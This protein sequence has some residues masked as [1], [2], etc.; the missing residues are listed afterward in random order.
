MDADP[1]LLAILAGSTGLLLGAYLVGKWAQLPRIRR[2][3]GH[4]RRCVVDLAT[5]MAL[6]DVARGDRR[7]A[8]DVFLDALSRVLED[9]DTDSILRPTPGGLAGGTTIALALCSSAT[10]FVTPP[11]WNFVIAGVTALVLVAV[12]LSV[13]FPGGGAPLAEDPEVDRFLRNG[14]DALRAQVRRNIELV[15]ASAA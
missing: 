12:V 15:A 2:L 14:N 6:H 4:L 5:S 3:D 9:I 10:M 7:S 1:L 11:P 13:D 8:S